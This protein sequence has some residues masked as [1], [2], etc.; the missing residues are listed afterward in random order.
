MFNK[1]ALL[2]FLVF[3]LFFSLN[4]VIVFA[5][6]EGFVSRVKNFFTRTIEK[7]LS[8]FQDSF[9]FSE[10]DD[11][12]RRRGDFR[13]EVTFF[14]AVTSGTVSYTRPECF[15]F[16]RYEY[17]QEVCQVFEEYVASRGVSQCDFCVNRFLDNRDRKIPLSCLSVEIY[18]QEQKEVVEEFSV[19]EAVPDFRKG[20][21]GRVTFVRGNGYVLRSDRVIPLTVGEFLMCDDVVGVEEGSEA[22]I[23][24]K[25]GERTI[26]GG[27]TFSLEKC[28]EKEK[29]GFLRRTV[30][31][32]WNRIRTA[33]SGDSFKAEDLSAGAG[34]R[35]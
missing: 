29:P 25:S 13:C 18:E 4:S 12:S 11:S 28:E 33:V 31:G 14:S 1:K 8:E 23:I 19:E 24:T 2:I 6:S 27:S 34:V 32:L 16:L 15:D 30:G 5:E 3:V 35:G 21:V 7:E 17:S 9:E 20:E 10:D 26:S 22:R